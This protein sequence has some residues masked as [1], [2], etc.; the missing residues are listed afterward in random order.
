[1]LGGGNIFLK[2]YII[3]PEAWPFDL[4]FDVAPDHAVNALPGLGKQIKLIFAVNIFG[5]DLRIIVGFKNH[6]VA[7]LDDRH[8]VIALAGEAPDAGT[9][10]R[11]DVGR[12]ERGAGVL[13]NA[14]L[15]QTERTPWKLDKLDHFCV[16]N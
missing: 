16:L 10:G 3:Q 9:V 4:V 2:I 1:M 13:Q 14:A 15:D 5:D 7:V 12:L 6:G 11:G 8:T